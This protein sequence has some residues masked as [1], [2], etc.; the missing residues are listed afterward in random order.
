[1][2]SSPLLPALCRLCADEPTAPKVVFVPRVQTGGALER[3]VVRRRG[4]VVGLRCTTPLAYA[5][6]LARRAI[7]SEGRTELRN[8]NRSFLAAALLEEME[9]DGRAEDLPSAH[10]FAR[11][12]AGSIQTLRLNSV[13]VET[14][15]HR[16]ATDDAPATL[17]A[18]GACYERYVS[19]L[20]TW[21]LFDDTD[22]FLRAVEQIERG[23]ARPAEQT[24]YAVTPALDLPECA[25]RFVQ[26]LRAVGRRF[27]R[28]GEGA[29]RP[30]ARAAAALFA[31]APSLPEAEANRPAAKPTATVHRCVRA[32]GA[33]T[34]VRAAVRDLL[35]D[36]GTDSQSGTDPQPE[37]DPQPADSPAG[38]SASAF[39]P[40][41]DETGFEQAEMAY[42]DFRPYLSLLVDTLNRIGIASTAATGLPGTATR[43][44]R[45]L[46]GF[47]EW[48]AGRYPPERLVRLLRSGHLRVDRWMEQQVAD[49]RIAEGEKME[50]HEVATLL[51]ERRYEE[52]RAGYGRALGAAVTD[53]EERIDRLHDRRAEAGSEEDR[54][55]LRR[56]L[57]RE[58]ARRTRLRLVIDL[59]ETLLD[60]AA[61]T[62][63]ADGRKRR[64]ASQ[65]APAS[66]AEPSLHDVAATSRRLIEVF[67]PVDAPGATEEAERT[68]E[69][70]AR[71]MFYESLGVVDELPVSTTGPPPRVAAVLRDWLG[72]RYVP[73]Q[74]PRPGAVHLVPLESAGYTGRSHLYVVGADSETL[75]TAG[76]DGGL[77]RDADRRALGA[78]LEGA[79]PRPSAAGEE[80][81]WRARQALR[82]HDGRVSL[83]T[84]TVDLES[85]EERYPSS[86]F[87]QLEAD[88]EEAEARRDGLVPD[89]DDPRPVL[90]ERAGWLAAHAAR[91]RAEPPGQTAREQLTAR[92][93]WV[94]TGEAAQAARRSPR[95]TEHD[96]LLSLRSGDDLSILSTPRS[97]QFARKMSAGR[98]E[99]LAE[100]PY[101][102]F[103]RYVLGVEPLDEP[104]LD[105]E[106]WMNRL[107]HGDIL[108]RTFAAFIE[109]LDGNPP[110]PLDQE[111]L[112]TLL[113]QEVERYAQR[114]APPSQVVRE[115][116]LRRLW[117]DAL[118]FLR[119]EAERSDAFRAIAQEQGFGFGAHRRQDGDFGDV[120]LALGDGRT[121]RLRGRIDRIDRLAD[122]SLVVW[123]YKTG[124]ARA[125]S[126]DEPLQNGTTLQW[127]LYAYVLET[128]MRE[129]V[130]QSGYFFT[131]TR[132]M[133]ERFVF[134]P[135]RVRDEVESILNDLSDMAETG[136]FPMTPDAPSA[137]AWLYRGFGRLFP[138]LRERSRTL[139]DKDWPPDRPLPP[140]RR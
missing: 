124:S 9:E 75:S 54:T 108:H 91:T 78:S 25:Y 127:A 36:L 55:V 99:T 7:V 134:E 44:G 70:R 29:P 39:P 97:G 96:G 88:A 3:A 132:E 5:R 120:D 28:L 83:Y 93:P 18:V 32:V 125:Y 119:A 16:A 106:P 53:V 113:K 13:P 92:Y 103:L 131:S 50:A 136:T 22:L 77:L 116:A 17:A 110:S 130:A 19:L 118:V 102:Y 2:T 100:T 109:D 8:G 64:S 15:R 112:R 135:D 49:G 137:S 76:V 24:V 126:V 12:I 80:A 37:A 34:E 51:A 65:E 38:R 20:E 66:R 1:M 117:Q 140:T 74:R 42:A 40:V 58:E 21:D 35:T 115:A 6:R 27:V 69:E 105:D 122:D 71:Q 45:L 123:D 4:H 11:M 14:V 94:E 30:P 62:Q 90:D 41:D 107:R 57:E 26:A 10:R 59:V 121:L 95:Y 60:L 86:L 138:H 84:R 72:H 101:I 111:R 139:A 81:L 23:D 47:Y 128:A 133:G 43:T 68:L 48:V 79:L 89:P 31:D 63:P 56:A 46:D 82:R 98:L 33:A 73:P 67:G 129:P 61:G 87:L 85:G 104:A 114:I 52:G